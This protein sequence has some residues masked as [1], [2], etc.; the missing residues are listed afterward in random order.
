M[1]YL[2]FIHCDDGGTQPL[3]YGKENGKYFF[4]YRRIQGQGNCED[5]VRYLLITFDEIVPLNN[6]KGTTY[7]GTRNG[8]TW[9]LWRY[10]DWNYNNC[11]AIPSEVHMFGGRILEELSSVSGTSFEE[12]LRKY[13]IYEY[14]RYWPQT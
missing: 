12:C 10:S 3:G 1:E 13:S 5:P 4:T 8:R 14:E 7:I 11:T 9:H 6:T 2:G